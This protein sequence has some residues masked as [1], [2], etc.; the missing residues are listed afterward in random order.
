MYLVRKLVQESAFLAHILPAPSAGDSGY[1]PSE[2]EATLG[3]QTRHIAS[4][5]VRGTC[6]QLVN[7][8]GTICPDTER[9]VILCCI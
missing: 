5:A 2:R 3:G 6:C 8:F 1:C 9:E 7:L 4:P